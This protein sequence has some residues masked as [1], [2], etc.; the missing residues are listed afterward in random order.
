MLTTPSCLA[1]GIVEWR[2]GLTSELHSRP[3]GDMSFGSLLLCSEDVTRFHQVHT[4]DLRGGVMKVGFDE[5][6]GLRIQR[7]F[8]PGSHYLP[9][10]YLEG[11]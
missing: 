1:C 11:F 9:R 3:L 8:F 4:V 10:A 6:R 2:S 5:A 7:K